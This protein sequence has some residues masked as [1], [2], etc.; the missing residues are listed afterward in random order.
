MHVLNVGITNTELDIIND[1]QRCAEQNFSS[2]S[3]SYRAA[4]RTNWKDS[5]NITINGRKELLFFEYL[6]CLP[7]LGFEKEIPISVLKS[8]RKYVIE[9]LRGYFEGDGHAKVDKGRIFCNSTS[10]RL[11]RQIYHVLLNLGILSSIHKIKA[12]QQKHRDI[13]KLD[14]QADFI[15][16]RARALLLESLNMS[17]SDKIAQNADRPV[18]GVLLF[19]Q[20]IDFLLEFGKPVPEFDQIPFTAYSRGQ[21]DLAA[22]LPANEYQILLSNLA[23]DWVDPANV[24]H[25]ISKLLAPAGMCWF[26]AF[27]PQTARHSKEVLATFDRYPHFNDFYALQD[28]GDALSSAGFQQ[29]VVESSTFELEY[30][31]VDALLE[32]A[33]KIFGINL[34]RQ[35]RKTLSA[36]GLL[37][38]FT[39]CIE[40]IIQDEGKFTETV[41]VL[42]V[43]ARK[44]SDEQIRVRVA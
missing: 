27:G 18:K 23:F 14:N 17:I 37:S 11:I 9:F 29:I 21:T 20:T 10:E 38:K 28:I 3:M 40:Q 6:G 39:A 33:V 43:H 44:P 30:K 13:R 32:D 26:S 2:I 35:R 41:E 22:Q 8:P 1:I 4:K 31:T 15:A 34:H 12:K 24:V 5:C 42:L 25:L 36:K 7:C 16:L 19:E